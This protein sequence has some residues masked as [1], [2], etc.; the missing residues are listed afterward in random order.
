LKVVQLVA[1]KLRTCPDRHREVSVPLTKAQIEKATS[2]FPKPSGP[3]K[4]KTPAK[5]ERRIGANQ[6]RALVA[7][8]AHIGMAIQNKESAEEENQQVEDSDSQGKKKKK[9]CFIITPTR[10]TFE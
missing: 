10:G 5:K 8:L 6:L 9:T 4:S 7:T 3:S 1:V 2:H